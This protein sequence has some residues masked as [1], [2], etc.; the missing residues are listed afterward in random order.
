[1]VNRS[2]FRHEVTSDPAGGTPP[3][4][5][6]AA[7]RVP[8]VILLVAVALVG[9]RGTLAAPHWNGPLHKDGTVIGLVF[10]VVLAA[11]LTATLIRGHR[12]ARRIEPEPAEVAR[13]PGWLWTGHTGGRTAVAVLPVASATFHL[14][15]S[16]SRRKTPPAG[17]EPIRPTA[18][19][20]P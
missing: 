20:Q 10:A 1:M 3:A 8:L 18:K 4:G 13:L 9:L 12:A 14:L 19:G 16:Q 2:M 7:S 6:P 5:R 17:P 15:K 11:L